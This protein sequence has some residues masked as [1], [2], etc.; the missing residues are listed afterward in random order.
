[1][2]ADDAI[3]DELVREGI[4]QGHLSIDGWKVDSLA[5]EEPAQDD[6]I[7][8]LDDYMLRYGPLL[9]QQAERSLEP[10]HVPSRDPL[11]KVDLI[12]VPFEAQS[13]MIEASR[14]ALMRQKALLLVG[15][16]GTGKTLMGMAAIHAHAA[17]WPYR[18]LVFCPG[19]LV[20]KWEREIRETIPGA[21]VIQLESWKNL[22]PLNRA[23]RPAAVE[24]Y[25]IARD[26]AKLGPRWR[27]AFQCR[28]NGD[29]GF[30]RCPQCGLRLVDAKREPLC[31][32]RSAATIQRCTSNAAC[33]TSSRT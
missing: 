15:E 22:L 17:G 8:N 33:G 3:L 19:Q 4:Q 10:L 11:P 18:A 32:G 24:W 7:D 20:H 16:M 5:P 2:L 28:S 12:R 13:H 9:G 27:T 6:D 21:S 29:D 14:K 26:R 1:M 31:I 23:C 25:V 30:L